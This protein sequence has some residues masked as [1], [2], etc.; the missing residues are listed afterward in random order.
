MG[1]AK[2][3]GAFRRE[4]KIGSLNSSVVIVIRET[5]FSM[6]IGS[7]ALARTDPKYTLTF[8]H[9]LPTLQH[10]KDRGVLRRD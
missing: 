1:M 10:V 4:R 8:C 7:P 3:I 9:A 5:A 2:T 6:T